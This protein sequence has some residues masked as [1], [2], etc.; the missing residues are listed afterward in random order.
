[1][2]LAHMGLKHHSSNSLHE[3]SRMKSEMGWL[4][5]AMWLQKHSSVSYGALQ[6]QLPPSA[7]EKEPVQ[8]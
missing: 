2:S 6:A 4:A 5:Q 8:H 1:M 7:R 3:S